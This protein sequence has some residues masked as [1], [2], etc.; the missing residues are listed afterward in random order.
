MTSQLLHGTAVAFGRYGVLIRGVPGAGKSRLALQ[1]LDHPGYGL[2]QKLYRAKLVADDQ[3]E[4]VLMG[5]SIV[6][7]APKPLAGKLEVRGLGIVTAKYVRQITLRMVVDMIGDGIPDR[8]PELSDQSI[9]IMGLQIPR[10]VLATTDLAA[11]ARLR[12]ALTH[13]AAT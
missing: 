5:K 8:M 9:D 1:L 6:M 12:A 13:Y 10:L 3:V 7:S 2:G 4:L 11:P